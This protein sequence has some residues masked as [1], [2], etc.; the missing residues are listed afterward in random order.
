[1]A[2]SELSDVADAV[3]IVAGGATRQDSVRRGLVSIADEE[4]IVLVHDAARPFATAALFD[5]VAGAI[6][7][8]V[9]AVVPVV[10]IADTVLR[11][12][13]GVLAGVEPRDEL[14]FAQTPQG[15][16]TATLRES[17]AKADAAGFSFT[18]DASLVSW[19]GFEVHTVDGEA[20]NRKITTAED[21]ADAE[22]R[23]GG[24]RA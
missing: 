20:A 7:G 3:E 23:V 21:L 12:R 24:S 18:D 15:F 10:P 19:A 6:D 14:S 9:D 16:R 17:H 5:R 8:P 1:M 11:V 13:G 22:R 4:G 2:R